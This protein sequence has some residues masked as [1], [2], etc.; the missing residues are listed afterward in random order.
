MNCCI[1]ALVV[2]DRKRAFRRIQSA[3]SRAIARWVSLLRRWISNSVP[4]RPRSRV[5]LGM[6]NSRRS[7]RSRSVT[8]VGTKVGAV[9]M[10]WRL[11]TFDKL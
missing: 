6:K 5:A 3:H 1:G 10:N 8:S 7:L 4:Y 11:S 2:F 9:K